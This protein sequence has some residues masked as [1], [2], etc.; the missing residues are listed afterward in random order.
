MGIM[1]TPPENRQRPD[2]SDTDPTIFMERPPLD[3]PLDLA[4][5]VAPE[6]IDQWIQEAIQKLDISMPGAQEFSL[7]RPED[8]PLVLLAVL[9]FAYA[10]ERFISSEIF[11][12]CH[13]DPLLQ[14]R[15]AGKAPFPDEIEHFRRKNRLL[16]ERLLGN[17]L[18]R[19]VREKFLP[20]SQLAPGLLD[21]L[22][23]RAVD[24]IDTARHMSTLDTQ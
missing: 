24:Q 9:L 4:A 12:A 19:A 16:L 17:L 21:S 22:R 2:E 14:S 11:G 8:R 3:L 6:K 15:C 23:R 20:A 18:E 7:L 10:T 1:E 5:W 13:S